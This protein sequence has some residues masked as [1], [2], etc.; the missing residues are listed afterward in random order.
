[1]AP[2]ARARLDELRAMVEEHRASMQKVIE[3]W[4]KADKVGWMPTWG[5]MWGP[6]L[7]RDDSGADEVEDGMPCLLG[8]EDELP[9]WL[10]WR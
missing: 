2:M 4:T 7:G 1:M 10:W 3:I 6:E 9:E 5:A 8:I